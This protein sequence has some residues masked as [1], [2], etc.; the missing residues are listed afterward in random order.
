M[1]KTFLLP[2]LFILCAATPLFANKYD[3]AAFVWPAYQAEPRW[4][5]LGIFSH[6]TGEWQSVYAAVAKTEG[7][8]HPKIPI[9]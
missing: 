8:K 5:E 6:G 2:L 9:W 7:H 1:T 3:I 4:K